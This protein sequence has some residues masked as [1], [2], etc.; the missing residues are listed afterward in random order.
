M[1]SVRALLL[2][3]VLAVACGRET[4]D[5]GAPAPPSTTLP[6]A[7]AP[8]AAP[9]AC[10]SGAAATAGVGVCRGGVV[11]FTDGPCLGEVLPMPETCNGEDDDCNGQVDDGLGTFSCGVGACEATVPACAGGQLAACTPRAPA[12]E[13][14]DGIDNDCNGVVDDGCPCVHVAPAGDDAAPGSAAR[15]LRT[16]G[17]GSAAP[18]RA[19][20]RGG[21]ASPRG[22]PAPRA[23][24]TPRRW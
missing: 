21:C 8:L 3:S 13:T 7:A 15:P 18:R 5:S 6:P 1:T 9:V 19:G 23:P 20:S 22:P 10:Y 24:T 14:C 16:I 11:T 17:A 2:V 12:R 4:S